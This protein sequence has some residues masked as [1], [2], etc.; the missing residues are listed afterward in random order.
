MSRELAGEYIGRTDRNADAKALARLSRALD[1]ASTA[2]ENLSISART[3]LVRATMK[4]QEDE[5]R[6]P[7]PATLML[8]RQDLAKAFSEIEQHIADK[9]EPPTRAGLVAAAV[10]SE[11]RKVWEARSGKPAPKSVRDDRDA[12]EPTDFTLF[13]REIFRAFDITSRV[14][15]A[16][17]TW[18]NVSSKDAISP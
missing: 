18:R 10:V 12:G 1:D 3:A 13:M 16:L 7:L 6:A 9:G 11:C 2:I 14:D 8:I 4:L 15:S 5:C 17:R